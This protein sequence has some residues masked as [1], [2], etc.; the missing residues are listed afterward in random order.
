MTA[1]ASPGERLR[2]LAARGVV[3]AVGAYDAFSAR[4]V[5]EAGFEAVY[6]SGAALSNS[7]ALPDEGIISRADVL[8][9]TRAIVRAV[10]A[11]V[12]VDVDTGFGGPRGV[13][14][15]VRLFESAGAAAVQIEDQDPRYKRCGHLEGKRLISAERMAEKVRAAVEAKRD[16]GFLVIARTDARAVEGLEGALARAEAYRQAGADA[17]FPEALTSREEFALFRRRLPGL[18]VAN[19]TEFGKTPWIS[20]GEFAE[21]GFDI[22]LHPATAFRLAARAVREALAQMRAEGN[23]RRLAESG[24]LMSRGE[25]DRYLV[26]D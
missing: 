7:L 24:R 13:A 25:I 11:P 14:A 23:Q 18:L 8:G 1:D 21:L 12:I 9:A 2:A 5:E 20:D 10:R 15:T 16:S 4:L 26:R 22:V 19:M 6:V 3:V 17:I